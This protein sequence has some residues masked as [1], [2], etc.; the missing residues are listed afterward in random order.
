MSEFWLFLSNL[1]DSRWLLPMA[2]VLLLEL[3]RS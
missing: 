3:P 1:G 2:M